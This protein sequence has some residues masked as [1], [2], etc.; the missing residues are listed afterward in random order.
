MNVKLTVGWRTLKKH[1]FLLD[2]CQKQIKDTY[3][4]TLLTLSLFWKTAC[5]HSIMKKE[6]VT[7]YFV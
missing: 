2:M 7:L 1:A 4:I 5:H 3:L 6:I